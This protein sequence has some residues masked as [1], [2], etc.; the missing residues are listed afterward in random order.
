MKYLLALFLFCLPMLSKA[1]FAVLGK[2][3][4]AKQV[5]WNVEYD[6]VG[7][8]EFAIIATATMNEGFHIWDL[9]AGGDGSLINTAIVVK[10]SAKY[11][12]I[13]GFE[14]VQKPTTLNLEFIEGPVRW[15]ENKVIFKAIYKVPKG[16]K[17]HV[18][19]TYQA[20]NHEMCF[21]PEDLDFVLRF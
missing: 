9:D 14:A 15:H 2:N 11:Q 10:E 19:V 7:E 16:S 12:M 1:Q 3:Q 17:M 8:G 4:Q 5:Q 20:C 18:V 21:P 13:K 6:K